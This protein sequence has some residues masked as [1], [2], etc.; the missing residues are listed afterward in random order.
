MKRMFV[1]ISVLF[2][3]A[4]TPAAIASEAR[5]E[6]QNSQLIAQNS[7]SLIARGNFVTAEPDHPTQGEARIIEENGQRYL[8]LNRDFATV[9]GPD[10]QVILYRGNSVPIQIQEQDYETLAPLQAF[11]G[12]QRYAIPD[13]MDIDEFGSIAVW[14][15]EFNV[16]FGYATLS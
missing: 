15:R 9:E 8:V 4:A 12:Q 7:S 2:L 11:D 14:C 10:V 1:G 13:N 5:I 16:T 6:T 3:A